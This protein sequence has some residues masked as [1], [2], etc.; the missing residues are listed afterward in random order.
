MTLPDARV[1]SPRKGAIAAI[2]IALAS[3][4]PGTAGAAEMQHIVARGQTLGAIARKY[5]VPVAALREANGLKS[6]QQIHPGLSLTIPSAGGPADAKGK[7]DPKGKRDPKSKAAPPVVE[8]LPKGAKGAKGRKDER[9]EK[10][11]PAARGAKRPGFVRMM[12]GS[13]R[14]DAQLLTRRGKLVPAALPGL[15]RVLRYYPTNEKIAIDPRLATLIGLVSDHFG[16]RTMHIVSGFRPY[17]PVQYAPHSNHN[18]GRAMDFSVEG[19]S[20]TEL[21]DFCRTFRN[22]GVGYYPNGTFVHLDVRTSKTTWVDY[23]RSG[24]AP[25]Y[26]GGARP[27]AGDDPGQEIEPHEGADPIPGSPDAAPGSAAPQGG[28]VQP[29]DSTGGN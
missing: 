27:A 24:E 12:R 20:N 14:L 19:I 5:H 15:S 6:W 18:L 21:R 25:R 2:L 1:F 8:A 22:A 10:A 26:E 23:S 13:E 11:E 17:S 7:P 29:P 9:D 16:G 4:Y 28:P 3:A